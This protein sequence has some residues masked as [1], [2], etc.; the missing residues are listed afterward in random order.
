MP[1]DDFEMG[2]AEKEGEVIFDVIVVS[3]CGDSCGSQRSVGSGTSGK[4]EEVLDKGER[5]KGEVVD[6]GCAE[7]GKVTDK[8][9]VRVGKVARE[10]LVGLPSWY[11]VDFE[12]DHEIGVAIKVEER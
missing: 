1:L 12:D 4:E 6:K 9:A 10:I 2:C 7:K 8:G 3:P 5:E 11:P